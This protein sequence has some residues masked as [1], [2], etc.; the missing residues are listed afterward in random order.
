MFASYS[1][2]GAFAAAAGSLA[3]A[4]PEF[5]TAL[6]VSRLG[7]LKLMFVLYAL[8]GLAGG[9][10]YRGYYQL[11]CRHRTRS[12]RCFGTIALYCL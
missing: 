12:L 11:N 8:L 3:A 2:I 7:A 1:L 5:L 10:M 6:G 9:L 4:T